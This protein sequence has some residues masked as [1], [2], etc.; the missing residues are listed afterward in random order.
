MHTK[1]TSTCA[2][3]RAIKWSLD[4]RT[5]QKSDLSHNVAQKLIFSG[6]KR[7]KKLADR[8]ALTK[9]NFHVAKS[10]LFSV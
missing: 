5:A 4:A 3:P 2:G 9:S 1:K 6:D 7:W 8:K 10:I